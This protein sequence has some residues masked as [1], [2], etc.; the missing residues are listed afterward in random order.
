MGVS[1]S[2]LFGW[3]EDPRGRWDKL[4]PAN[5]ESSKVLG[6]RLA[7]RRLEILGEASL[8]DAADPDGRIFVACYPGVS[9]YCDEALAVDEPSTL[10]D[11]VALVP[12][13]TVVVHAMSG[14]VDGLAFGVWSNGVLVRALSL[15]PDDG[16]VE[17]AG[18]RLALELPFWAGERP[19]EDEDEYPLPFHP[20]ELGDE[21]LVSLVGLDLGGDVAD[22]M[23]LPRFRTVDG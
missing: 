11:L 4:P 8:A 7:D 5:R 6:E 9:I 13:R 19:V 20:L 1:T 14:G 15:S 2:I 12:H 21:V 10:A 23:M 3:D 22:A 16:V 18:A 17:D